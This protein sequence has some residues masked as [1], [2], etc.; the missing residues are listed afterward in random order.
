MT[1]DVGSGTDLRSR[2]LTIARWLVAAYVAANVVRLVVGLAL[3]PQYVQTHRD[4][5]AP[6]TPSRQGAGGLRRDRA[7]RD[8]SGSADR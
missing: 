3:F 2:L 4:S 1:Q 8:R 5:K 6:N 7:R